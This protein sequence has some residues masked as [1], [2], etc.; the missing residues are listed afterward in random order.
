MGLNRAVVRLD[1]HD[2]RWLIV[3]AAECDRLR[4]TLRELCVDVEHVGSTAVA[5][6]PAKPILDIAVALPNA[7][8]WDFPELRARMQTMG[9]E[10]ILDGGD[11][12]GLLFTRSVGDTVFVHLHAVALD[13]AQWRDYLVFRDAL[14]DSAE[15]RARY[16]ALKSKLATQH[17]EDR[18][19]YTDAKAPF[20]RGVINSQ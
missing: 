14:R 19:A 5:G 8:S 11:E 3:G 10:F 16:A 2:P 4:G 1:H 17:P 15:Q 12:G 9:Y 7:N 13:D 18:L 6:L 20:I